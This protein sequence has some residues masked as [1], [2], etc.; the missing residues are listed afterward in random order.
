M[1][2]NRR[3]FTFN[4]ILGSRK[5]SEGA[6]SGGYRGWGITAILFFAR[7]RWVRTAVWDGALSL[8]SSQVCS[9]ESRGRCL[10]TFSQCPQNFAVEPQIQF[11]LLG[12]ILHA[13][14]RDV[15]ESDNHALE[16]AFDLSGPSCLGDGPFP[17]GGLSLCLRVVTVNPALI[18][19][20][21][22]RQRFIV[23]GEMTKFSVDVD[24]LL[25]LV[26]CQDSGHE[27]GCDR[28]HALFRQNSLA[29]P[30]T[31][32]HLSNVAN[33]PMSILTGELLNSWTVSGDV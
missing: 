2:S 14:P 21:G 17:L 13:N 26:S 33:Y 20:D 22:P 19:S 1:I 5:K 6:K 18:T 15:I 9:R 8:W 29:C 3:P 4:F 7:N 16:I 10:R 28:V 30:I 32:F 23:G 27:F 11:G 24:A 12:Q 31:K 25:L